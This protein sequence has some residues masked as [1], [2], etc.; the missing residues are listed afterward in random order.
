MITKF[1]AIFICLVI[2]STSLYSMHHANHENWPNS[3][4]TLLKKINDNQA[5]ACSICEKEFSKETILTFFSLKVHQPRNLQTEC[6]AC[7]SD[8]SLDDE[9]GLILQNFFNDYYIHQECYSA[10]KEVI[11]NIECSACTESYID[12]GSPRENCTFLCSLLHLFSRA[13]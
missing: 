6:F 13:I 2:S 11:Q 1:L 8:K 10:L 3:F 12:C 9:S 5:L 7:L 4:H